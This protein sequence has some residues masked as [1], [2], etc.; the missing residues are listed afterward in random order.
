MDN[1]LLQLGIGGILCVL[2][3]KLVFDFLRSKRNGSQNSSC[4]NHNNNAQTTT[5]IKLL[6]SHMSA[7]NIMQ[8]EQH[9][10]CMEARYEREEAKELARNVGRLAVAVEKLNDKLGTV[11][12]ATSD[13]A[14]D[15]SR[16]LSGERQ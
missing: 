10:H 4:N 3:L 2:V 13:M 6:E 14:R 15:V 16:L 12:S 9:D 11:E 7:A 8:M 5:L 1:V